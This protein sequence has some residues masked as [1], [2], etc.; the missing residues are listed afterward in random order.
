ME[1]CHD[2]HLSEQA[3][4]NPVPELAN[5]A[6]RSYPPALTLLRF[7]GSSARIM[8]SNIKIAKYVLVAEQ[9]TNF[10]IIDAQFSALTVDSNV[11]AK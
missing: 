8:L 5:T 9:A 7:Q 10:T 6:G 1:K 11:S 3:P 2:E 4:R